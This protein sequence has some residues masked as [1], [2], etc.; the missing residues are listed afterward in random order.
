MLFDC[1]AAQEEANS[2]GIS[3]RSGCFCNPGAREM[4]LSFDREEL[5]ACLREK[6]QL[7]P[8]Q[9]LQIIDGRLKQGALR[10]SVRL[11][12]NFADVYHC[13]QFARNFI[14]RAVHSSLAA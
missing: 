6:E 12:T 5:V 14:D 9:F 2:W 8:E 7:S 10:V 11:A 3:L 4:A 13:M 1:Y